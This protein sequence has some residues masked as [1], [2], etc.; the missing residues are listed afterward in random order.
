M[1]SWWNHYQL[2][3]FTK[4]KEPVGEKLVF[5]LA[6]LRG[7]VTSQS[8]RQPYYPQWDMSLYENQLSYCSKGI[9]PKGYNL[10]FHFLNLPN[11]NKVVCHDLWMPGPQCGSARRWLPRQ[12]VWSQEESLHE[13]AFAFPLQVCSCRTVYWLWEYYKV[14]FILVRCPLLFLDVPTWL[15]VFYHG[16][17]KDMPLARCGQ[18]VLDFQLS[19]TKSLNGSFSL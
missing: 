17:K 10:N 7:T 9:S 2:G 14:I 8:N 1:S 6:C 12:S 15:S 18:L 4:T 5:L 16:M 13:R 19:R 3:W 11:T